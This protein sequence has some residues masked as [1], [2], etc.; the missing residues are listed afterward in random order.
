[1]TKNQF[2]IF[3]VFQNYVSEPLSDQSFK[4]SFKKDTCFFFTEIFVIYGPPLLTLKS[5]ESWIEGKMTS[6]MQCAC[7]RLN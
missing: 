5:W 4:P 7:M 3:F 6:G 1:M 2:Y